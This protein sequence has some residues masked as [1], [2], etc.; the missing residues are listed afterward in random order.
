MTNNQKTLKEAQASVQEKAKEVRKDPT[1]PQ[2][3]A[4]SPA[5]WMND[6]NGPIFY[7]G[8]IHLFYQHHPFSPQWDSIHWGHMKT[9]DLVHWTHLPIAFRPSY[10]RGERH[11][12][13]GCCV[14]GTD[15]KPTALYTSIGKKLPEQWI[16]I[17]SE[18]MI[19]W[20][21][22]EANPVMD[23]NIHEESGLIIQDWR[24][25]YAW[26]GE[27][28]SYYCVTGGHI[29]D[30]K[31]PEGLNPSVFLYK[32]QDLRNWEFLNVLTARYND[33]Q[34]VPQDKEVDLGKNFECPNLFKI[35]GTQDKWMLLVSPHTKIPYTVGK[36]VDNKFIPKK[37]HIFDHSPVFYAPNSLIDH[38]GRNIVIG[39]LRGKNE[40]KDWNGCLSLPRVI[41]LNHDGETITALPIPEITQLR[42]THIK[43]ENIHIEE[44]KPQD[45]LKKDE[46][47]PLE[48]YIQDQSVEIILRVSPDKKNKK[49]KE[50]PS[51]YCELYG[52]GDMVTEG[53]WGY[54]N[55]ESRFYLGKHSGIF[56]LNEGEKFL[57]VRIFIDRSVIEIFVNDRWA[58]SQALDLSPEKSLGFNIHAQETIISINSMEVWGIK[59]INA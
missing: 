7:N 58:I 17:G 48:Q 46:V 13:S 38:K 2:Y 35:Q 32:S 37:W 34:E 56:M 21:K 28:G 11:C 4:I 22:P 25:P 42:D 39:W 14:V 43:I 36:F 9:E 50:I 40:D 29:V 55:E 49:N 53:T 12:Y 3:H 10:E 31:Y 15:G 19:D 45:L 33:G 59:S 1:R 52:K 20:K 6:P 8:E 54:D 47:K 18:D 24:D 44:S 27:H 16:A 30:A 57:E 41:S 23:M 5:Y 26:K 51:F